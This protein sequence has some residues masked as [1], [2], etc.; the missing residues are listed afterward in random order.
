MAAGQ[1]RAMYSETINSKFGTYEILDSYG[2]LN[3]LDLENV[4]ILCDKNV[5][6][7][8]EL[9]DLNKIIR[10]D[11]SENLKTLDSAN[12]LILEFS[13]LGI[14]RNSHLIAIGGGSVQDIST[15]VC[16]I[17][18][19]GIKWIYVPS[20]L[21][22]MADSCIGGKSSINVG[23]I[24]NLVGNFYP[25][26]KVILDFKIIES[27]SPVA[28]A[29]GLFEGVKICQA[30]SIDTAMQFMKLSDTWINKGEKEALSEL[31]KLS[32]MTKKWFIEIDEFDTAERKLLNYGHS[33]G[34]ALESATNMKIPHGIAIGI[35]M[36]I[37]MEYSGN[38]NSKLTEYVLKILNWAK[39]DYS[40]VEFDADIMKK[41]LRKDKKNSK[42]IQR[43]ILPNQNQTIQIS[44]ISLSEA[45]LS[46]QA[47]ITESILRSIN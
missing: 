16:S 20:T 8:A 1:F 32:L 10:V 42:T 33:F 36:L 29:C 12:N 38:R 34:H 22:A 24:K 3:D 26:I 2:F 39:C 21:M 13:N 27:L 7:P 9:S 40:S 37:A 15:F 18:M 35:G 46:K 11:G 4:F 30:K 25:P 19:R 23:E 5:S 44:E 47:R 31:V 43:L 45:E 17:Y 28:I 6:I 14:N 41:S